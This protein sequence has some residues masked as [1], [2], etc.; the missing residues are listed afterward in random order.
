M[1]TCTQWS[2][3]K[4]AP[5]PNGLG[6]NAHLYPMVSVAVIICRHSSGDSRP[7]ST[8]A[9]GTNG[10]SCRTTCTRHRKHTPPSREQGA[11]G[12][13]A[14]M[15]PGQTAPRATQPAP[16]TGSTRRLQGSKEQQACPHKGPRDKRHLVPHNLHPPQ[17]AHAAF[18]GARSSRPA[19]T[20]APGTKEPCVVQ[21]APR[22]RQR[23]LVFHQSHAGWLGIASDHVRK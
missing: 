19:C 7:A 2:R 13:P 14:Q 8:N 21:P 4:C 16:A 23:Q 18:K 15:P 22:H 1:R 12:L 17:E 9:P 3:F 10:T 11:A 5:V 20:K 6:P